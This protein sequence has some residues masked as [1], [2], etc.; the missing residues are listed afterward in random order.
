MIL[1]EI[2]TPRGHTTNVILKDFEKLWNYLQKELCK[3][4]ENKD[5]GKIKWLIITCLWTVEEDNE[6][7]DLEKRISA[8]ED[9]E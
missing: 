3:S 5:Y 6:I 8:L 4:L 7:T 1:F 9:K 2:K